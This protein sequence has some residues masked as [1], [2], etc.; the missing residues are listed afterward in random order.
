MG[1]LPVVSYRDC[2]FFRTSLDRVSPGYARFERCLFQNAR[3]DDRDAMC[4]EFVDCKFSGRL[5][6]VKFSGR[7]WGVRKARLESIR[8][9]NAFVG[10][11][12]SGAELEDCSILGGIDLDANLWP[13]DGYLIIRD[14]H[15][16]IARAARELESWTDEE[17]RALAAAMLRTYSSGGHTLQRDIIVR[18]ADLGPA[19]TLLARNDTSP[20]A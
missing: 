10:N 12:F 17:A 4:A 8:T 18:V 3:I 13:T 9:T 14:A 5:R 20:T 16:Q 2:K 11:D 6:R 1:D 19:K 7:P 15:A